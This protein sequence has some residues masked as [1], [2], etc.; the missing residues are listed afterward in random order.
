MPEAMTGNIRLWAK[1][2][3]VAGALVLLWGLANIFNVAPALLPSVVEVGRQ[4]L[5]V[6]TRAEFL[7]AMGATILDAMW[8][9]SI[10]ALLAIPLGIIVGMFP[11]VEVATRIII[12]FGRSFP[13]FSLLPILVLL[14]SATSTMKI[15]VIAVACF[16]PILLQSIYG[17]RRLE[18]TI[19]D[20]IRAFRIPFH[21]RFFRVLLPA[22][23]PFIATGLRIA[24]TLSI[25]VAIGVEIISLA[26][27]LGREITL[28]RN[29]NEIATT[30][31]YIIY[32]GLLG[33][34]V[35]MVWD[36]AEARLLRWHIRTRAV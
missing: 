2:A 8:G 5:L 30:Y 25:L 24:T 18:P 17:A 6:L 31:A 11:R 10:A 16:F 15:L 7:S 36:V 22:A 9:F 23:G 20:T 32:A 4:W 13:V 34:F 27:G 1:Q 3:G 29:Y 14:L 35:N 21:L 19:V 33:I 28:S 26:P 12:D